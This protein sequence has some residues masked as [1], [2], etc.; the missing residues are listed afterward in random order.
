M[1]LYILKKKSQ[2][3]DLKKTSQAVTKSLIE[4]LLALPDHEQEHVLNERPAK[5][6]FFF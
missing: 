4:V 6:D 1:K 3:L 5:V 2:A